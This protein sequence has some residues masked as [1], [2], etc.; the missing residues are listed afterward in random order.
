V[1]LRCRVVDGARIRGA[2]ASQTVVA[3]PVEPPSPIESTDGNRS[4]VASGGGEASYFGVAE[5]GGPCVAAR[6]GP[7]SRTLP[8]N[9][10]ASSGGRPG[11]H[12]CFR[13]TDVGW[14][15][16]GGEASYFGV[17]EVG[18]PCVAARRGPTSR[19][20]P[21]NRPASSGGRS[22]ELCCFGPTAAGWVSGGRRGLP[23]RAGRSGGALRRGR[24]WTH[25]ENASAES[26]RAVG[27]SI[28]RALRL[29]PNRSGCL[30]RAERP[31]TSGWPKWAGPASRRGVDPRRERFRG[32]APRR[33]AVD[34]ESFAASAQPKR[35][36]PPAAE[37]PPTSGWP[38]W[39]GPASRQG[40]DP[41][42]ERFRG[43]VPCRWA[44]STEAMRRPCAPRR[45]APAPRGAAAEAHSLANPPRNC[46]DACGGRTPV[47]ARSDVVVSLSSVAPNL[48]ASVPPAK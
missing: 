12:C 31:P 28:G 4:G 44:H 37:R 2:L 6:R 1:F 3:R 17:A 41:R 13:P 35:G 21:R 5:V 36:G 16:G 22:G 46:E 23:L 43:I 32:I 25:V 19:T 26:S 10:P 29:R 8:R 47:V 18:G 7:T 33:R 20:L 9:R 38:K 30:R 48:H 40:V 11:E 15:S 45:A 14:V 39:A 24:A 34:R 27:R 42:R